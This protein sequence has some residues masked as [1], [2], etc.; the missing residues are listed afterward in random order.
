MAFT[1]INTALVDMNG[2]ANAIDVNPGATLIP[3]TTKPASPQFT[4]TVQA[5]D[6]ISDSNV[7]DSG[8]YFSV[9]GQNINGGATEPVH[10]RF[11]LNGVEIGSSDGVLNPTVAKPFWTAT[12]AFFAAAL[13]ASDVIGIKLWLNSTNQVNYK[14]GTLYVIP[15]TYNLPQSGDLS[16]EFLGSPLGVGSG[17]SG[18]LVGVA[19]VGSISSTG[20]LVVD[21]GIGS[22]AAIVSPNIIPPQVFTCSSGYNDSAAGGNIFASATLYSITALTRY[23]RRQYLS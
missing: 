17:P 13:A 6:L 9:Y 1:T 3:D 7:T 19:Y 21:S 11:T 2:V 23:F 4:Y 16:C 10:Y 20:S 12:G 8:V 22:S 14:G 15:R 5:G 18:A